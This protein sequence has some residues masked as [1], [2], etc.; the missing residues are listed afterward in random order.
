[1]EKICK[2]LKKKIRLEVILLSVWP[3]HV[4]S[5]LENPPWKKIHLSGFLKR[6]LELKPLPGLCFAVFPK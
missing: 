2:T 3:F 5:Q 6:F 4:E 1:M